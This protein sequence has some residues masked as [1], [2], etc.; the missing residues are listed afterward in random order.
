MSTPRPAGAGSVRFGAVIGGIALAYV[1]YVACLLPLLFD[2]KSILNSSNLGGVTSLL[3]LLGV[4]QAAV[5]V[6]AIVGLW[7][8]N[9]GLALGF[10]IGGAT[11]WM[12]LPAACFGV[13]A[14][15]AVTQG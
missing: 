9:R 5:L 3:L 7:R 11:A 15:M 1:L 12:L 2:Y 13:L 6:I 4:P 8:R 14:F 10:I